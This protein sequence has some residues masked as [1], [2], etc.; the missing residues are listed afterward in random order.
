MKSPCILIALVFAGCATRPA[1]L[2]PAAARH[3]HAAE[4]LRTAQAERAAEKRA[5][6]YL[7]TA[8]LA[9]AQLD[10]EHGR[11]IYNEATAELTVLLRSADGGALWN[12]PLTLTAGGETYR[13]R[14][15]PHAHRGFWAP[16]YFT[17]F[18][19]AEKV[20]RHHLRKHNVQEGVGGALVG[21]RKKEPR[22]P[23]AHAEGITGVVTATL[24][25]RGRDATLTLHDPAEVPKARVAGRSRQ[26]EADFTAPLAYYKAAHPLWTGIMGALRANHYMRETGLYLLQPYDPHRIP[27][28]FVHGLISTPQ[29]WRDVINE[30]ESDPGLRGRYQCWVFSYPTG[31]LMAYSALRLREELEK[32]RQLYGL[33]QGIVLVGHSMGGLLSRM[34]TSTVTRADWERAI[35]EPVTHVFEKMPADSVLHRSL[36]VEANPQVKRAVFICTPHRGSKLAI[37]SI[38]RLAEHLIAL[39]VTIAGELQ[40]ELADALPVFSGE[41]HVIPDSITSLAP[42]DPTLRVLDT[43]PIRTPH[44]TILGDRG[45]GNSPH[46]SD[47]VVAYESSH[48]ASARSQKVVPGPHS[49]VRLPETIEELKRI[50][51]LHLA[52]A[53]K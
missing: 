23:F 44:H 48:L 3:Y 50:L 37:E 11:R 41:D 18:V 53:G 22:E 47:G 16:D 29:V 1:E 15:A 51:R 45:K 38:G 17:S 5:A 12:R 7:H 52:E 35:G 20:P 19:R 40:D 28:V 10:T 34:Q 27:I 13:L 8:R 43:V 49:S 6:H 26:L 4:S 21:V 33:H 36:L 31:N 2:P 32:A 24:D 9:A 14:F 30:V 42:G 46:S 39:P 25:F